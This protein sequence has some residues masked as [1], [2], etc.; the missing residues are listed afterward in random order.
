MTNEHIPQNRYRADAWLTGTTRT[1]R[2]TIADAVEFGA[3]SVGVV[4]AGTGVC[5][6]GTGNQRPNAVVRIDRFVDATSGRAIGHGLS[7]RRNGDIIV[8]VKG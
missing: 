2:E 7:R 8:C 5:R 6:S 4:P 1:A 3:E